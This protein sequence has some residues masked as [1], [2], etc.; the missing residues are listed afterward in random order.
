MTLKLSDQAVGALLMTLQKCLSEE[1]D[2]TELLKDWELENQ[3]GHLVVLN[4]PTVQNSGPKETL[5]DTDID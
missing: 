4:P 1:K 3:E 5:F 2:I